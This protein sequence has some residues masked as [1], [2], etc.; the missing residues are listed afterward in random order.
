M[1][2]G[3]ENDLRADLKHILWIDYLDSS[4]GFEMSPSEVSYTNEQWI[5]KYPNAVRIYKI[6]GK[7]PYTYV[8][9][10]RVK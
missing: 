3:K 2:G 10:D 4:V 7:D 5:N 8:T 6:W 1:F 9:K